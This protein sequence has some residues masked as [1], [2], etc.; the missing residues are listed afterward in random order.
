MNKNPQNCYVERQYKKQCDNDKLCKTV[1]FFEQIEQCK[2]CKKT[3]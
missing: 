1:A 2:I 3:L